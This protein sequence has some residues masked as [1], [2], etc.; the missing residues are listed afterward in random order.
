[1]NKY[2]KVIKELKKHNNFLITSHVS[3]EG[4]SLGSQL[5]FAYLLKAL[6]K[7]ACIVNAQ[8]PGHRYSFLPKS[9]GTY[10][11]KKRHEV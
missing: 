10:K 5:A 3:P 11:N 1:M 2:K 7:K 8:K 9:A 6:G 4:D